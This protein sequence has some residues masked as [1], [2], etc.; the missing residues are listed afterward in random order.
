MQKSRNSEQTVNEIKVN[1]IQRM[2]FHQLFLPEQDDF[3]GGLGTPRPLHSE[4]ARPTEFPIRIETVLWLSTTK[5][6]NCR[7]CR[8]RF[9]FVFLSARTV[10]EQTQ[11]FV[12]SDKVGKRFCPN[13]GLRRT[14]LGRAGQKFRAS[15]LSSRLPAATIVSVV[16]TEVRPA[17][18]SRLGGEL[19]RNWRCRLRFYS[20]NDDY[21]CHLTFLL[22]QIQ[23]CI[24]PIKEH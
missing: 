5:K 9:R 18:T 1:S 24:T 20:L 14:N 17:S 15:V 12:F 3:L 19:W 16:E 4:A 2:N 23:V 8:A 22:C 21:Y 10:F 6:K 7:R 13:V 11:L